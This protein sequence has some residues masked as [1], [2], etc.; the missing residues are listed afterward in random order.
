MPANTFSPPNFTEMTLTGE[1]VPIQS[2][3]IS[4]AGSSWTRTPTLLLCFSPALQGW[5]C[6]SELRGGSEQLLAYQ[7]SLVHLQLE[8]KPHKRLRGKT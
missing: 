6:A 4:F 5:Q 1:P 3:L 7:G 2:D 8:K